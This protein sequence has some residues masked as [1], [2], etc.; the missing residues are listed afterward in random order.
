MRG[1]VRTAV[2]SA[3]VT[4]ALA[5]VVGA[6]AVAVSWS[7]GGAAEPATCRRAAD[8]TVPVWTALTDL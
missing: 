3:A 4:L 1:L 7:P 5:Y 2:A 6:A 8:V